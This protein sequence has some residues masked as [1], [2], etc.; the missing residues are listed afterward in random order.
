LDMLCRHTIRDEFVC[1]VRWKPGTAVLWDNRCVMHRA[2]NDYDGHR[3][4]VRR[5]TLAGDRPV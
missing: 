2:L 4:N 3:R 5:V 1:R